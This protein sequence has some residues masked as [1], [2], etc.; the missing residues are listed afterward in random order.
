M[1]RRVGAAVG[2]E[3]S[4]RANHRSGTRAAPLSDWKIGGGRKEGIE[5]GRGSGGGL[6]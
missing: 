1:R 4:G 3:W 5:R 6:K 2:E